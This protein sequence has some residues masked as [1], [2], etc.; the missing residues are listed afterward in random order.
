MWWSVEKRFLDYHWSEI[1]KGIF[2]RRTCP[3]KQPESYVWI[4][5]KVK[6]LKRKPYTQAD[7]CNAA[8]ESSSMETI[9]EKRVLKLTWS[10]K[11]CILSFHRSVKL[12]SCVMANTITWQNTMTGCLASLRGNHITRSWPLEKLLKVSN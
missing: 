12:L 7:K 5:I 9:N 4:M 11:W 10:P 2:I 3:L 6:P 1:W 8:W